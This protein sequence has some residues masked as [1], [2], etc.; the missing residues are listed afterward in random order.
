M[1]AEDIL[2]FAGARLRVQGSGELIASFINLD[3]VPIET[4]PSL[5]MS[6]SPTRE[7]LLLANFT[8]QR[9]RFRV[10]TQTIDEKMIINRII[11][12]GKPLWADYPS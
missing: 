5:T 1:G 9:V 6:L 8:G 12:Y 11:I 10:Q 4:L 7:P 3:D 2:H